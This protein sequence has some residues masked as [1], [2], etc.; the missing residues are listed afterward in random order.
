MENIIPRWEW[1]TFGS[2]FGDAEIN[3]RKYPEGKTRE[4]DEIYILSEVS[5]DNT[6]IRDGLMDIKTLQQ[7][8]DDKLEQWMPIMKGKF[9]IK[10]DEVEKV[11]ASFKVPLPD[12]KKDEYTFDEF[13]NELINTQDKLKAVNV[14]KKRTG[15]TINNCIVEIA[16]VTVNNIP[17]RTIAVELEDPQ[18]VI[19]TVKNL[20]LD[21]F[22]NINYLKGLKKAVGMK[23]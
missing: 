22:E 2:N 6:K 19:D 16:E 14:H 21:Q 3:V 8:N 18:A 7:I 5:M 9:P 17:T 10:K 11:F 15:F 12:F 13:I 20:S 4:S 23:F 1:R